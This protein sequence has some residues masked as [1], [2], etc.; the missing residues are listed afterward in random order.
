MGRF[1]GVGIQV[2]LQNSGFLVQKTLP[3]WPLCL[4]AFSVCPQGAKRGIWIYYGVFVPLCQGLEGFAEQH[5]AAALAVFFPSKPYLIKIPSW[6]NWCALLQLLWGLW[7]HVWREPSPTRQEHSPRER[8]HRGPGGYAG[9][10][11]FRKLRRS[12]LDLL[13]VTVPSVSSGLRCLAM[14]ETISSPK[15]RNKNGGLF[16]QYLAVAVEAVYY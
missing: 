13:P 9:G 4:K 14:L 11:V 10:G 1:W 12:K 8:H 5:V 2:L 3:K 7:V 15:E 6:T 16:S